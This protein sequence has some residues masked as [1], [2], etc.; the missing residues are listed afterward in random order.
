[1]EGKPMRD[2]EKDL[3]TLEIRR[4]EECTEREIDS[5]V[6][7][8]L[9]G[10]QV[11][12][13][14]LKET[15]LTHGHRLAFARV[16]D[17]IAG[18]ASIKKPSR[19][20]VINVFGKADVANHAA[21][22]ELEIAWCCTAPEYRGRGL[23]RRLIGNL[24]NEVSGRNFFATTVAGNEAMIKIFTGFDFEKFGH[25]FDGRSE[26]IQLLT[27]RVNLDEKHADGLAPKLRAVAARFVS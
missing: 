26:P 22:Y 8:L 15:V 4:P 19:Y 20:Y 21:Y 13:T 1:M 12:H 18:I 14:N 16:G 27:R 24:L 9:D 11:D 6:S 7:H 3:F 5:F 2:W 25:V 23:C 10:G 17:L